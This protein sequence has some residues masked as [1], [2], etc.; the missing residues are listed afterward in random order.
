MSEYGYDVSTRV[1]Y[2]RTP[3]LPWSPG[4]T[5]DDKRLADDSCFRWKQV[6]LTEKMDGENTTMYRGGIH[7]R[8]INDTDHPSRHWVKG[9]WARKRHLI[10]DGWRICGENLYAVHSIEYDNLPSYFMVFAIFDGDM[11]LSW[12]RTETLCRAIGFSTVPVLG[13]NEYNTAWRHDMNKFPAFD[14]IREGYVVRNADSFNIADF[15]RNVAKYVRKNHVQ[16][17]DHWMHSQM[18]VNGLAKGV[19]A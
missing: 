6:V 13:K 16:T 14:K 2:P 15:G 7:A 3:H 5:S 8:S 9:L 1:K 19:D 4:A 12:N 10:P 17:D 11:C 18:R